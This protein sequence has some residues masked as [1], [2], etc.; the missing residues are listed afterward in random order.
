MF[1]RKVEDMPGDEV[2]ASRIKLL[3]SQLCHEVRPGIGKELAISGAVAAGESHAINER[4][5]NRT[6]SIIANVPVMIQVT[7]HLIRSMSE[8]RIPLVQLPLVS[9]FISPIGRVGQVSS[10]GAQS[11]K[12]GINERTGTA[13]DTTF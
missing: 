10:C 12:A 6:A 8:F 3:T 9:R 2:K 5:R 4:A 13:D 7:I 11:A 1:V